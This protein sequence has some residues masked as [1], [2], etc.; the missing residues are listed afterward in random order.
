MITQ[1]VMELFGGTIQNGTLSVSTL[2]VVE[3]GSV[4]AALDGPALFTK[5]LST[6][7]T[8]SSMRPLRTSSMCAAEMIALP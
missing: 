1:N 7:V 5:E 8:L 4:S 2:F 3:A 6:T